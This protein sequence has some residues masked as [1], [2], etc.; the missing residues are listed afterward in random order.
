MSRQ[1]V[2]Y[3]ILAAATVSLAAAQKAQ[4]AEE[5]PGPV[6]AQSPSSL[7]FA[8]KNGDPTLE[9]TN[10]SFDVISTFIAGRPHDQRL[11]LRKTTASKY[12]LGD[13][14]EEATTTLEAWPLGVDLKQKPI[15][16]V[17][18]SGNGGQVVNSAYFVVNRG[19]AEVE[20]WSIYKLGTGQHLFDTYAPLVNFS[21]T[22]EV[23]TTR[24]LGLEVPPDDIKDARLK[25]PNV[26]AV[27]TY[28]SDEAVKRE[29]LLTCDDPNRAAELR[30]YADTT[31]T[32]TVAEGR[33]PRTR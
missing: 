12:V 28:A 15:Y 23:M 19:L 9:I 17:K 1:A 11:V 5:K 25:R 33:P 10:V 18:V 16:T 32:V 24:Y 2:T 29:A 31:R 20:W 6:H 27:V 4:P 30:S 26:V 21:I 7:S 14:G 3:L 22:T 8:W 13:M